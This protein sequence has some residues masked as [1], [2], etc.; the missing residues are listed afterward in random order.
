VSPV[1]AATRPPCSPRRRRWC[2]IQVKNAQAEVVRGRG[3]TEQA[4][5]V[6][7]ALGRRRKIS[8]ACSP[9]CGAGVAFIRVGRDAYARFPRCGQQ[10]RK[11][12]VWPGRSCCGR[13]HR[14]P[15]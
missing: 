9:Q 13:S 6:L 11:W 15:S 8:G 1:W 3:R 4:D 5:R 7:F 12:K 2:A 10:V 14:T